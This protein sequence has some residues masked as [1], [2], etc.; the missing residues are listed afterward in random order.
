MKDSG[1]K[2]S[3]QQSSNRKTKQQQSKG[4]GFGALNLSPTMLSA[5][6]ALGYVDP[7]PIQS[8]FIPRAV[9][10]ADV[11]GQARTGT[12]KTAAFTIPILEQINHESPTLEAIVLCPTRELSEQ[13]AVEAERL[14]A[15]R[16]RRPVLLVGGRPI[17]TQIM[18]LKED[19]VLAIG[20]PGRVIDLIRRRELDVSQV[21]FVVLDEADRMLDIGFRPAIERILRECPKERQTLLLSATM[22]AEVKRLAERYM[23]HPESVDLSGDTV[24]TDLVKQFFVTVDEKRK[25]AVL[26]KLLYKERP[27]Q[28]IVFCRTKRG[29]DKLY[30]GFK[31]KLP[32]VAVIHGD[33][34]QT[35]RDRV[36][37]QFRAGEI[38]LL[39]ATD[40]MGRGIDVSGISH[41]INFDIPEYS[42]D[43]VHRIGRTGRI[44]SDRKGRAFTFVT[45]E[46]GNEL[47]RIEMRINHMLQEYV[48]DEVDAFV[49]G[50][51]R[52]HVDDVPQNSQPV[53]DFD[54]FGW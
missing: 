36:M 40:V 32:N 30:L 20:T 22:P 38:R 42:D 43:Y 23:R 18:R 2:M 1:R 41:I 35:K 24:T 51:T 17:R 37:K 52:A 28:A 49:P 39:I 53:P 54:D 46:E 10:G 50:P 44:S 8:A 26:A 34:P 7:T 9:T 45:R 4:A 19:P 3:H 21:K 27:Q 5:V 33:L 13:V 16:M 48:L 47:T 29:S 6:E 11:I 31:G 25:P 12:G 14:A 15:N